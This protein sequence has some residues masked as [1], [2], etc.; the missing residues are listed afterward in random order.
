MLISILAAACGGNKPAPEAAPTQGSAV[1]AEPGMAGEHENLTPELKQFHD[2]LAPRY[3]ADKGPAR[4][5]QTCDAIPEFSS[6]AATIAKAVP[7]AGTD[8]QQWTEAAGALAASIDTLSTTC[9]AGDAAKFDADFE[10][11]H[12]NFHKLMETSAKHHDMP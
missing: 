11:L 2:V 1:A 8:Q 9:K 12:G 3:H 10:A 4:Q 5:K 7:P 6:A